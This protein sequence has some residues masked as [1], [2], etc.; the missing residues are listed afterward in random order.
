LPA[1]LAAKDACRMDLTASDDYWVRRVS[2][3]GRGGWAPSGGLPIAAGSRYDPSA[4]TPALRTAAALYRREQPASV[5]GQPFAKDRGAARME[6]D[7]LFS[8]TYVTACVLPRPADVCKAD[9]A[10]TPPPGAEPAETEEDLE[11]RTAGFTRANAERC[12]DVEIR[13]FHVGSETVG[14]VAALVGGLRSNRAPFP[15]S[16][17]RALLATEPAMG[18]QNDREL[19]VSETVRFK[20]DL[21]ALPAM[22]GPAAPVKR[23]TRLNLDLAGRKSLNE[24]FYRG[25]AGLILTHRRAGAVA[26][27]EFGGAFA[28]ELQPLQGEAF[29]RN[30]SRAG[31]M[32]RFAPEWPWLKSAAIGGGYRYSRNHLLSQTVEEDAAELRAI[33]ETR[34]AGF[35]ARELAGRRKRDELS[36]LGFAKLGVWADLVNPRGG[37]PSYQRVA[38][39]AAVSWEYLVEPNRTLGIEMVA[40]AGHILGAAPEYARFFGGNRLSNF[41][42]ERADSLEMATSPP[43]PVLRS[44]GAGEFGLRPGR[45]AGG[46][47]Y[48][49]LNANIALPYPSWSRELIPQEDLAD[50]P[51]DP[52][53]NLRDVL[54]AGVVTSRNALRAS[55]KRRGVK[56]PDREA[57]R[58]ISAV[59]PTIFY[60]TDA[61][62]VY[63]IKPVLLFDV[64]ALAAPG[65]GQRALAAAGAGFQ[66]TLVIVR[67]EAGYLYT[68]T[69]PGSA[70]RGNLVARFYVQNLF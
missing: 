64:A 38:G 6:G 12:V 46:S 4:L 19:G 24:D 39:L 3:E 54:K 57:D 27:M 14:S 5:L 16:A 34:F 30:A 20:T 29:R 40:G 50:S 67:F 15:G 65:G 28:A 49:S 8:L 37:L 55:L 36:H 23:R 25:Q 22:F 33:V 51:D 58:T 13:P 42:L 47:T 7:E 61:A 2:L 62:N 52:S 43:G 56:D 18:V 69:G 68:V 44:Y 63:S 10:R 32:L 48:W 11:V 17:P 9:S 1:L 53:F 31:G 35:A 70:R 45:V 60:L 66:A 26:G 41:L 59:R 21:L